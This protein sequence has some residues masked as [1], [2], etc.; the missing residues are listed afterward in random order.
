M[1]LHDGCCIFEALPPR[2]DA[3]A[4]E[5]RSA[6]EQLEPL[7]ALGLQAINVPEIIGGA[8]RPMDAAEF[9]LQLQAALGL[10]A[11]VNRVVV[12]H[13]LE[14]NL[15]WQE[16]LHQEGIHHTMLVGGESSTMPYPGV[17]LPEALPVMAQAAHARGGQTGVVTIPTRRNDGPRDEPQRLLAK[18][19]AGANFAISQILLESES[20]CQLLSDLPPELTMPIAWSLSPVVRKKDLDFLAWLGVHIPP[21]T[22]HSLRQCN[23]TRQRRKQSLQLALE[24]TDVLLDHPRPAGFC[25]EHVTA[26]NID[27][28]IEMAAAVRDHVRSQR[29]LA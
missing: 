29:V 2:A 22:R 21:E 16:R 24:I 7:G 26:H 12:H 9:A 14:A 3:C 17:T 19:N 18:Q 27:A 5:L 28:A 13:N 25:I 1:E 6:I 8:Y 23:T 20:P 15:A 10:P 4:S 11:I